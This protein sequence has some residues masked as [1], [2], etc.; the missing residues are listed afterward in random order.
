M[1]FREF[2]NVGPVSLPLYISSPHMTE[3]Y[4]Y[5][6][7][8]RKAAYLYDFLGGQYKSSLKSVWMVRIGQ[9]FLMKDI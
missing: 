7:H 2:S 8:Q 9:I 6:V 4:N 1:Y 5:T 3:Y